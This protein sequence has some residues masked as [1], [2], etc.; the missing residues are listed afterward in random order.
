MYSNARLENVYM[1]A[2]NL[3]AELGTLVSSSAGESLAAWVKENKGRICYRDGNSETLEVGEDGSFTIFLPQHTSKLR[4]NF[5][6]A[7]ELGHLFLHAGWPNPKAGKYG[8]CGVRNPQ[9]WE[10]NNF[11]GELLMPER[12][13]K[14]FVRQNGASPHDLAFKFKV[15]PMA[16]SVRLEVLDLAI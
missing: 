3:R 12:E 9:E 7:H 5:T 16:A 11:A 13:V 1:E 2:R 10:A 15:S 4:D 6:L 14:K 8:R